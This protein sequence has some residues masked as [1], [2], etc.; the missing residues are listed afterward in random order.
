MYLFGAS[1][2][3]KVIIEILELLQI[4]VT[5]LYDDNPDLKG[6]LGYPV[7]GPLANNASPDKIFLI[8]IGKNKIRAKITKLYDLNYSFPIIHPNAHISKRVT[9]GEGSVVMGQSIIN[10]DSIIGKHAIIN[11]SAS[12]DHDCT[13]MDFTHISP[14][15]TLS[16]GVLVGKGTHI[17]SGAVVIPNIKL[18]KW[19]TIGAGAVVTKDL[20]DFAVAVGNPARIIRYEK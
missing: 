18:G 14:N 2:H 9:I 5:G 17:G 19:V 6:L 16:G 1:G 11:T 12:V 13:L 7:L 20:P 3:A 4:Q 8:S 10:S 15:A